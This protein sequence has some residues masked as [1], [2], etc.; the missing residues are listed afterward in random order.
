M[1]NEKKEMKGIL[2]D[3]S[4]EEWAKFSLLYPKRQILLRKKKCSSYLD[5]TQIQSNTCSLQR[6]GKYH[7]SAI[8]VFLILKDTV[9]EIGA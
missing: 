2:W 4:R 7:Y 5:N 9:H 8:Q 1:V 6:A 3:I